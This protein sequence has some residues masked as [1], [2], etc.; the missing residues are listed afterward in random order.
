MRP[1]STP[2]PRID[3]L[4]PQVHALTLLAQLGSFTKVALRLGMSKAAVSQRITELERSVGQTLVQRTTRSVRLT[5]AGQHLVEQTSESFTLIARS[6]GEA[7][8]LAAQPRG[9]VRVTAPVA[10]GRQHVA[11]QI[12]AFVR[13]HPDVRVELELSD[14]LVTLAHEGFDL[15]V[16]HTSAPPDNH[17][18]WKLCGSRSLLVASSAYLKR[19]GTPAHPAELVNHACLSY[20]RAG[21]S[22]WKF[23]RGG[24]GEPE[25]SSVAVQGPLRAS[26]SEVLRDAA[27]SGLGVALV[28]DFS[29]VSA[30]RSKRLRVLLPAWRPIGVFGDA[31][32]AMH[33]WS[34]TTPKAVQA[35]VAHLR[36]Q[37]EGGFGV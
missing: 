33:P 14:H 36:A 28:P 7:R 5:E 30:L 22:V 8:D 9:L 12:E 1:S 24:R 34:P 25:R 3:Q 13:A 10:L 26:N 19:H 31:I 17:V 20:L 23:E 27:M 21:P 37:L 11:P 2:D 15:A 4:W 29:A 6:V 16:R 18:A 32:Y 35:L